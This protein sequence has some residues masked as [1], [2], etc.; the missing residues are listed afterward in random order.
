MQI[1]FDL[2][3]PSWIVWL[4]FILYVISGV[5][6][7]YNKSLKVRLKKSELS[8]MKKGTEG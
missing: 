1:T 2:S 3:N 6:S 8:D 4:V 7:I 5:L